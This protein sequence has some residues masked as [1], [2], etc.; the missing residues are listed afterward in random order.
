MKLNDQINAMGTS[1]NVSDECSFIGAHTFKWYGLF[2]FSA[3]A[4]CP[5]LTTVSPPS[6]VI[7]YTFT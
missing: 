7:Y 6:K 5:V 4:P 1:H 2:L 3:E